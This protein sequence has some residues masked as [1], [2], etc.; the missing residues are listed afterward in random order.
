MVFAGATTGLIRLMPFVMWSAT[1]AFVVMAVLRIVT[2]RKA[3]G[4][5]RDTRSSSDW[6]FLYRV[7]VGLVLACSFLWSAV[8]GIAM[9]RYGYF[10]P[11]LLQLLL[12]HVAITIGTVIV[13]SH[14][15]RLILGALL[16]AFTPAMLG[17]MLHGD[18]NEI[19]YIPTALLYCG[20]CL[21][22]GFE[23]HRRYRQQISSD[24][25]LS[26]AAHRDPLT[27][28]INRLGL[29]ELLDQAIE[30]SQET[31][32]QIALLYIDLDGFKKIND[33]HTHDVGDRFLCV[34]SRRMSS[35]VR[36]GDIVAR[37]GGDEFTVLLMED[38]SMETAMQMA[39]R[40][41]QATR[42]PVV[43]EGAGLHYSASIGVSVYPEL[44]RSKKELMHS[45]DEAMYL[46]KA[47]G[48]GRVCRA[49]AGE[50]VP[51]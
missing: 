46:A 42:E 7:N 38:V 11:A 40:I 43:I 41:V 19:A 36:E 4:A 21:G 23:L 12:Y 29:N 2:I 1:G 47:T 18:R 32:Q 17:D 51:A 39:E 31:G 13:V 45:A 34:A 27:G 33:E 49:Y 37:V 25:D 15:R 16:L 35:C 3:R 14:D 6:R 8:T 44:A 26:V 5:F 48:K 9:M 10:A 50:R 28:V 20:Y 24:Y 30:Q 22:Q